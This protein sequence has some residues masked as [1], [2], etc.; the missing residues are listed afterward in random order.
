M[1]GETL[2][3]INNQLE[4]FWNKRLWCNLCIYNNPGPGEGKKTAKFSSIN[5]ILSSRFDPGTL[6]PEQESGSL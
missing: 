6:S 5:C 2:K 1:H 4:S 3:L